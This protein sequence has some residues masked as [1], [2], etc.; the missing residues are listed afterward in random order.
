MD[1]RISRR[2][3][4]DGVALGAGGLLLGACVSGLGSGVR[5]TSALIAAPQLADYPPVLTGMQGE[6]DAAR[7][8]PHML[9]DGTFWNAV[10]PPRSTG[11]TYDLV[12]VGGGI[13]GLAAA[14]IY[15]KRNK[16]ARILILDNHD[17]FGGHAR[18]NEFHTPGRLLVGYGGTESIQSPACMSRRAR[19][20]LEDIGIE[21]ERFYDYYENRFWWGLGALTFFDKET[22]G[23]DY[24]VRM[25]GHP[26]AE[27]LKDAPLA[28]QAKRDL[29]M[30]Y[31]H[32]KGWMHGLSDT[33]KK[34]RLSEMTYA[35][36]LT[37]V[38]KVDPDTVKYLHNHAADDWGYGIDGQGAIDNWRWSPGF[39]NLGLDKSEPCRYNSPSTKQLWHDAEPYIFHFPDGNAGVARL[40][41]RALIPEALPGHTMESEV[42]GRL[43]Y[44]KLDLSDNQVRIRLA[45]P[46][47]RVRN[48]GNPPDGVE[49]AYV[50]GNSLKTVRAR[51]A[52][53][54]CWYSMVPYVVDGLPELQQR[55]ARFMT[56]IP[57]VYATVQ[58]RTRRAFDEL[59]AWGVRHVGPGAR[60][61]SVFLDYP[62]SMGGYN[63][64]L[65]LDRPGLLH[66]TATPCRPGMPPRDGSRLGRQDMYNTPFA[67]YERSI[68]DLLARA[69]GPGGFDPALD[70]QAVTINRWAHG[71]SLEYTM[72][73]DK[74]FYPDGPFPGEVAAGPVGRISFANTD[75]SSV[76]YS[77]SAI[78]A[79][80]A[81]VDEQ[82]DWA[83]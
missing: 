35:Q 12:V 36:Y 73:W 60:W 53:M 18:R 4:L 3:F 54:A 14:H 11:E 30:L 78:D 55:A 24:S 15:G 32:P 70:I 74:D 67:D 6:T 25:P 58:L 62:V 45:S 44:D 27:L 76:A 68:R 72:P 41:V 66:M 33:E 8:M 65:D 63:Y 7:A 69:M 23:S 59:R 46:V 5:G 51:G 64:P 52:V 1:R 29:V 83:Q 49:V 40:L 28:E 17:D 38:A 21:V 22:W 16:Q 20:L 19:A 34:A 50:Q 81:A 80:Y 9:R 43:V 71:Y 61:I 37:D 77:D 2:D 79:A 82:M 48:V 10:G 57:L 39:Q 75:R 42:L 31:E 47:V 26:T 56:R 13:S